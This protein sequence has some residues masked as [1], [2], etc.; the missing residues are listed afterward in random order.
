MNWWSSR[1]AREREGVSINYTDHC[2]GSRSVTLGFPDFSLAHS[3][4]RINALPLTHC[5][6]RRPTRTQTAN[7]RSAGTVLWELKRNY[8]GLSGEEYV[9]IVVVRMHAIGSRKNNKS[10]VIITKVTTSRSN[11]PVLCRY[12]CVHSRF[13]TVPFCRDVWQWAARRD[14]ITHATGATHHQAR[15]MFILAMST[16]GWGGPKW[17]VDTDFFFDSPPNMNRR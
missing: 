4:R 17:V 8:Q 6:H 5:Y 2:N 16:T 13:I 12:E 1:R 3:H 7:R 10:A 14:K 15:S 9:V 11:Q